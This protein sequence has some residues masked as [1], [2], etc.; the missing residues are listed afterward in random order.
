[1]EK[2]IN[3]KGMKEDKEVQ[4][5]IEKI[6]NGIPLSTHLT[7]SIQL[8]MIDLLSAVGF[9][10]NKIWTDEE[11]PIL[12]ILSKLANNIAKDLEEELVRD[13]GCQKTPI[14]RLEQEEYE[15]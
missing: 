3:I 9:R 13:Y 2:S 11:E 4:K 5:L 8:A 15:H 14:K 10:E 7:V 12:K 1:M 6:M